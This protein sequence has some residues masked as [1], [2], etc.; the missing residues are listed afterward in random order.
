M[1]FGAPEKVMRASKLII[2]ES[3]VGIEEERDPAREIMSVPIDGHLGV[4]HHRTTRLLQRP[5]EYED[6]NSLSEGNF[7]GFLDFIPFS[8]I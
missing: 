2:Q 6:D 3:I 4:S 1:D 7:G 5:F 8:S